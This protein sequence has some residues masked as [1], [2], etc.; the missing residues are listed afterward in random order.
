MRVVSI[1]R[2]KGIGEEGRVIESIIVSVQKRMSETGN[3]L[4][5]V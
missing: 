4:C 3:T 1:R 2:R 5:K